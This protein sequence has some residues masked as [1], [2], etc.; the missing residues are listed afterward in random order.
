MYCVKVI[1]VVKVVSIWIWIWLV[2]G[3]IIL[4]EHKHQCDTFQNELDMY[5][6]LPPWQENIFFSFPF[7]Y[8]GKISGPTDP[9]PTDWV[10]TVLPIITPH[11]TETIYVYRLM[12]TLQMHTLQLLFLLVR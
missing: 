1:Q 9:G 12:R 8:D 2:I 7:Y 5:F 3:R 10:T 6:Y 11:S 4:L